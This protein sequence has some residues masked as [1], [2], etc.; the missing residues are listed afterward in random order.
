M[1]EKNSHI[2]L[3][4]QEME[5]YNRGVVSDRVKQAWGV[6]TIDELRQLLKSQQSIITTKDIKHGSD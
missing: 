1:L 5:E 2:V 6:E 4:A 3:T